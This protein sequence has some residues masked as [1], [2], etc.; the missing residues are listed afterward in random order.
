MGIGPKTQTPRRI[1]TTKACTQCGNTYGEDGFAQTKSVFYPDGHLPICKNCINQYFDEHEWN[2]K[3]V[4]KVCQLADIPFVP[5][6][7]VKMQEIAG[8]DA[9][10]RYAQIF[11]N[12]EFEAFGWGEYY[13]EFL[14]L[15][16]ERKLED[17]I[18]EMEERK[19]AELRKKWDGNYDKE[20]FERLE[21]LLSGMY[22]TQN[23]NTKL[24]HDQALKLCKISL[25]IDSRI[26]EGG[27]VDKLLGSY[28][29]LIKVANFTPKNS[30]S[31]SDLESVGELCKWL[32]SGG[33]KNRFYDNV[34]RDVVDETMKNMQ[35]WT[36]R[37]YVNETGIGE[38]VTRRI[39]ALKLA[40]ELEHKNDSTYDLDKDYDLIQHEADSY[41]EL[42][43]DELEDEDFIVNDN[44]Y[45]GDDD[46]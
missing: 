22:L 12:E 37:L 17:Q 27:D 26:R 35:S 20:D 15:R 11:M 21:D 24:Q 42:M 44:L 9:F 33:W 4:D 36:Q 43:M 46:E 31:A 2:W 38:E 14:R 7:W 32:E 28:E 19:Y 25:E 13:Q 23:I 16:E 30:K 8:D 29:K 18:P 34:T 10:L 5:K 39:E 1:L 45:G 41:N 40:D 6:E 3:Y